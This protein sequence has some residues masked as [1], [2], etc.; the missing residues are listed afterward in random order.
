MLQ[1]W[2]TAASWLPRAPRVPRPAVQPPLVPSWRSPAAL[3]AV[4][5]AAAQLQMCAEAPA[6]APDDVP[7]IGGE[8]ACVDDSVLA[9]DRDSDAWWRAT[10]K[11]ISGKLVLIHYSGCDDYWDEW[12]EAASPNLMRLD[13]DSGPAKSAF[14]MEEYEMNLDDDELL[15]EMRKR[16]WAENA[17]WQLNVF[18]QAQLGDWVG[19]CTLYDVTALDPSDANSA[20]KLTEAGTSESSLAGAIGDGNFV[21]WGDELGGPDLMALSS[22]ATLD[23]STFYPERGNMAVGSAFTFAL[24]RDDETGDMLLELGLRD[25][26]R[27]VRCK[28]LYVAGKGGAGGEEAEL[29]LRRVAVL[30]E[31][32]GA[33]PDALPDL[34]RPATPGTG[35]YDPPPG[36]KGRYCSLYCDEGLTLVAPFQLALDDSAGC[37]SLDWTGEKMRFQADRKFKRLDGS[38]SSFE[39]TEIQ[40]ADAERYPADFP[41]RG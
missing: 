41:D 20:V 33:T 23:D 37:V 8:P 25:G 39:L 10:V 7:R 22:S 14:Q 26:G 9:R 12:F 18:A 6:E 40:S 2:L 36:D 28:L 35:L 5:P 38:L 31:R 29:R 4:A 1:L 32:E 16:K 15:D 34:D 13:T 21:R 17:R 27:R 24:P 3:L 11:E 30:R 19:R